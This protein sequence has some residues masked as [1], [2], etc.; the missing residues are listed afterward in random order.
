MHGATA[1]G[2]RSCCLLSSSSFDLLE[3]PSGA[4]RRCIA[5]GLDAAHVVQT[6]QHLRAESPRA[7]ARLE[8]LCHPAPAGVAWIAEIARDRLR[9]SRS[10]GRGGRLGRRCRL[11]SHY[12]EQQD[13][14]TAP[15]DLKE[16]PFHLLASLLKS[17]VHRNATRLVSLTLC[18]LEPLR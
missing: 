3:L 17:R 9:G 4:N 1:A 15:D 13:Q 18:S 14:Q 8:L 5:V 16:F 12:R 10:R 2:G 6:R 7:P 11:C